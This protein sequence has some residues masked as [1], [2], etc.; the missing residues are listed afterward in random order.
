MVEVSNRICPEGQLT[1]FRHANQTCFDETYLADTAHLE[2]TRASST[3]CY[4]WLSL[5]FEL[6]GHGHDVTMRLEQELINFFSMRPEPNWLQQAI[7]ASHPEWL[8]KQEL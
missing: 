4:D 2:W 7:C 3:A 8:S 1:L 6:P 5:G